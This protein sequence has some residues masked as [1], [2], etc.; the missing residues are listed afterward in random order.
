MKLNMEW[1]KF[2]VYLLG[3]CARARRGVKVALRVARRPCG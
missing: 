1:F 3:A 2:G